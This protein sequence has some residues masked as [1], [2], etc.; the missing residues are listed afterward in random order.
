MADNDNNDAFLFAAL[1]M[2]SR[3]WMELD[4]DRWE[5]VARPVFERLF[6]RRGDLGADLDMLFHDL[7]RRPPRTGR[8]RDQMRDVALDVVSGY[9]RAADE[10]W[11]ARLI[12]VEQG[13][14][15]RDEAQA[16]H[17]SELHSFLWA[18]TSGVDVAKA[19]LVRYVP[20]RIYIGNP[21]P[22]TEVLEAVGA[23]FGEL[24]SAME[25]EVA[26][27][28]PARQG[29]WFKSLFRRTKEALRDDELKP[30]FDK[31]KAALEMKYLDRPQAE[32]TV[33]LADAAAK[34]IA[35]LNTVPGPCCGQVGSLLIV[36]QSDAHGRPAMVFKT[37]TP[38]EL[39]RLEE[40]AEMLQRPTDILGWLAKA[41]QTR[42]HDIHAASIAQPKSADLPMALD[43]DDDEKPKALPGS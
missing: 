35:V 28:L 34:L 5:V 42:A 1:L 17:A 8:L 23:A 38:M 29:S 18:V 21:V 26:E 6:R 9:Q 36:K 12:A 25:L 37:L 31:A 40:N 27:E 13:L 2:L 14:A 3:D 39:R 11:N 22:D 4:P 7:I 24:T 41:T 19:K 33:M 30:T 20:V 10:E 16:Q 15:A 32:V 43:D